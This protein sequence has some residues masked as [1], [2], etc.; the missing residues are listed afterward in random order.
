MQVYGFLHSRVGYYLSKYIGNI[1]QED[2]LWQ[3]KKYKECVRYISKKWSEFKKMYPDESNLKLRLID[4]TEY[5]IQVEF[6]V[7]EGYII[8]LFI[9]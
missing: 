3:F 7:K 6:Y 9:K 4:G 5:G 1:Y 8:S 2:F